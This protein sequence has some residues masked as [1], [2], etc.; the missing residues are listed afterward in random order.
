MKNLKSYNNV[1]NLWCKRHKSQ[2]AGPLRPE[3]RNPAGGLE[4]ITSL[5]NAMFEH[6][7]TFRGSL[8]LNLDNKNKCQKGFTASSKSEP[9]DDSLVWDDM[10][11]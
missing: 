2:C 9:G 4:F 3:S 1:E 5:R 7:G 11:T 8:R 10:M 6:E